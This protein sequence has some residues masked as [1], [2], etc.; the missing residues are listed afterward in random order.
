[1]TPAEVRAGDVVELPCGCSGQRA[2]KPISADPQFV[3][4]ASY[5]THA[6]NSIVEADPDEP[7]TAL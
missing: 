3:I 1:M 2:T 7:V 5:D 4:K 6:P